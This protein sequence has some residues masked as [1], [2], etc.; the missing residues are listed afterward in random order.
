M[1]NSIK[2]DSQYDFFIKTNIN[3]DASLSRSIEKLKSKFP[4]IDCVIN[5]AYPKNKNYGKSVYDISLEDFNQHTY[6][7]HMDKESC[8]AKIL[9]I[10]YSYIH[11]LL[12]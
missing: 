1:A 12:M 3:D 5:T 4:R 6:S 7:T 9:Y 11:I 8:Y 2:V 10:F